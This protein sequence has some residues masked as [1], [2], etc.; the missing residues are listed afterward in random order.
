MLSDDMR[1]FY[2]VPVF[3]VGQDVFDWRDVVLLTYRAGKWNAVLQNIEDGL[4]SVAYAEQAED[5]ALEE[6]V[7]AAAAEFRYDRELLTA[8]ETEAWLRERGVTAAEWLSSV[9]RGVLLVHFAGQ[10]DELPVT[11][12]PS[13]QDLEAEIRVDL[14][15]SPLGRELAERSAGYVA[16]AS[17]AGLPSAPAS[18]LPMP[19]ELPAGLD[20]AH[21]RSRLSLIDRILDGVE[22]FRA[23][24]VNPEALVRE[25]RLHQMEWIRLECQTLTFSD[26]AQA[27]EAIFCLREDGLGIEE[28]AASA[29][30][31]PVQ[32]HFFVEDLDPNLQPSFVSAMPGDVIG[33]ALRQEDHLLYLV[34]SKTMPSDQDPAVR[35]RAA[36]RLVARATAVEVQRRVRWRLEL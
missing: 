6:Q 14:R 22:R 32:A 5:E 30:Q 20:A 19:S 36:D 3:E 35:A 2:S 1:E 21:A 18:E 28:V 26:A 16:A 8:E 27:R 25:I 15:C 9:R 17:A 29:H 10:L 12:S 24:A 23:G 4:R 13:R 33:P 34:L 31:E 11:D 7:E